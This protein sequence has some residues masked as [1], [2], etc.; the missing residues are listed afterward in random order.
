MDFGITFLLLLVAVLYVLSRLSASAT[1][2]S[3]EE[4]EKR[5]MVREYLRKRRIDE[6]YGRDLDE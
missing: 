2:T 3:I 4:E 5:E 1:Q 6:L